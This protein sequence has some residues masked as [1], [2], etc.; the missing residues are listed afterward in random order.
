MTK[1]P[2]TMTR[3]RFLR[4]LPVLGGA[5]TAALMGVAGPAHA[6]AG[7]YRALVC[8]FLY[9]GNDGLNMVPPVDGDGYGRYAAVRQQV[10][11]PRADIITLNATHGLHP[12][13]TALEPIWNERRLALLFNVG[14]LARPLTRDDYLAWRETSDPG[15]VPESLF[16]HADQQALWE[17]ATAAKVT[18][19]GW[20]G[21]VM[22]A[23]AGG[24]PVMSFAGSS[25]FGT[26]SLTQSLVL[27]G[28]GRTFDLNG[29]WDG[30][31]PAA[32]RAAL[33]SLVGATTY[34][35]LHRT[36]AGMQA[37]AFA[38]GARLS[39]L[40]SQAPNGG[41]AD[42]SNPELSAAFGDLSGPM[43]TDLA[44]QLYQVAKMIKYRTTVGGDRHLF[45]VSLGGFDHHNN[46]LT[47]HAKLMRTLGDAMAAFYR[48]T[49]AL[50]VADSVTTFTESDFGR[51]FKPNSSGGT[52]H[53]WG[54][55]HLV[56]GGAVRGG[57]SYGTYPSLVLGGPDEA[58]SKDWEFQGRWIPGLSVD[59]YAATLT[60]W[61]A[62]ELNGR[63]TQI[64]PNLGA[65]PIRD[66]GF[67]RT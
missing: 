60:N 11:L 8:V 4:S 48:A 6:Q 57:A 42:A 28:P 27:P 21:R 5:G 50:G 1:A 41:R 35:L 20:G 24:S 56:I 44:R 2:P 43:A 49:Q 65:F 18:R 29:Y 16:S 54:N 19:A 59:Q 62:P 13:L 58:G 38:V 30:S 23:L 32:R 12:E 53:A 55:Q 25:R 7:S 36:Y 14:P 33:N 37:E 47:Q 52:D 64:L 67:M 10:A 39:T 63:L 22:E 34:D 61:F 3:R 17:T 26:G 31:Q 46:Q 15:R 66:L 40:L 51:T 45:F 9:G